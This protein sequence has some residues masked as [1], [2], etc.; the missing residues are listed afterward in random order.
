MLLFD[1]FKENKRT[2]KGQV[3][4]MNVWMD[5]IKNGF[6]IYLKV[7]P[8]AIFAFLLFI[9]FK[10]ISFN[11]IR[12]IGVQFLM[13]YVF[14][15]VE[16]VL[17]PLPNADTLSAMVG[18]KGQFIPFTFVSDILREKTITSVLQVAF[19]VLLTVPFGFFFKFLLNMKRRNVILLTFL[20]SVLIE[21][22]Q[23]TGLFFIYPGSYRLFDVDDLF[24]NTL[25][26]F[27]GTVLANY[28]RCFIPDI[29]SF[30]TI[31]LD[32]IIT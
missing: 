18:Y 2:L 28:I 24:L 5:S 27:S 29:D 9:Y 12:F 19:N 25:G 16:V 14:C 10:K 4:K 1:Q 22:A 8:F 11:P 7:A 31:R 3:I 26:G 13:V 17:F 32:I 21:T 15:L 6:E 20:L 30:N 23:L